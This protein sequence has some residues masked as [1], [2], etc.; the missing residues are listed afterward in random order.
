MKTMRRS[1][2]I[3]IGVLRSRPM[4]RLLGRID[5]LAQSPG[6]LYASMLL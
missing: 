1:Y 3:V 5:F 6:C 4:F 2:C